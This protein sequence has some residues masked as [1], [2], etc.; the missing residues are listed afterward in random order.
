MREQASTLWNWLQEGACLYVC[1]D[2]KRMAVDVDNALVEI[3]S[4][5]AKL[6][7][8]SAKQ[9]VKDL[10]KQKRYLRDVY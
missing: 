9:W 5:Q 10:A 8:P 6:P 2:A 1:G 7:L 4:Q 3:V